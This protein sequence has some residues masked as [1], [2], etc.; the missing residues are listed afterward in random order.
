MKPLKNVQ[1]RSSSRKTKNLTGRIYG[2]F[3]GLNFEAD[4]EI[5]RKGAFFKGFT[6]SKTGG[7]RYG[8]CISG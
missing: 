4:A 6:I 1:I 7:Y 2:I 3:R 8:G 5:G